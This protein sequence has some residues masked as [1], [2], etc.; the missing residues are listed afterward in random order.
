MTLKKKIDDHLRSLLDTF[1]KLGISESAQ[2]RFLELFEDWLRDEI[3][4]NKKRSTL[5]I[6]KGG[7]T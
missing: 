4:R 7:K 6:I 5:K 2:I 3:A 1:D